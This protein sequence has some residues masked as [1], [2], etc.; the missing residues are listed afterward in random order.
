[1]KQEKKLDQT[2][3]VKKFFYKVPKNFEELNENDRE[4]WISM[5]HKNLVSQMNPNYEV[6]IRGAG[7]FGIAFGRETFDRTLNYLNELDSKRPLKCR[8]NW[9]RPC[10]LYKLDRSEGL[11]YHVLRISKA[12]VLKIFEFG[13]FYW[14]WINP[15]GDFAKGKGDPRLF[16][17]EVVKSNSKPIFY[18]RVMSEEY[19]EY[20]LGSG[21]KP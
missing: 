20:L 1:M 14:K 8:L 17:E 10:S 5:V 3:G 12:N 9:C 21:K 2:K 19:A 11:T 16:W 6:S 15:E 18:A 13:E 7:L 4:A